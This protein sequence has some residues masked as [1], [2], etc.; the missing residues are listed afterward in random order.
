[1]FKDYDVQ[2]VQSLEER[3]EDLD[4]LA[5]NFWPTKLVRYPPRSLYGIVCG[6]NRHWARNFVKCISQTHNNA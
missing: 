1:M 2:R 3:S 4:S 6:M 5:L